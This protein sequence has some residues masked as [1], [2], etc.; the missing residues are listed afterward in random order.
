MSK[1]KFEKFVRPKIANSTTSQPLVKVSELKPHKG[2]IEKFIEKIT[3]KKPGYILTGKTITH[4]WWEDNELW[5]MNHGTQR[6]KDVATFG[7]YI[8]KNLPETIQCYLSE[9]GI[10][11][12][13]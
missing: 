9:G 3:F 7:W 12:T 11:C 13:R 5:F 1:K 4:L 2:S 6:R 10:M 8:A